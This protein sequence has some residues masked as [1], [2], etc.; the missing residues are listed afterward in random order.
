MLSDY[1][2]IFS[3]AGSVLFSAA[4][5]IARLPMSMIGVGIV[6]MLSQLGD[7]YWLAG[8][9]SAT[10]ALAA[11]AIGPQI[12]RL[13]DRHGQ[14]RVVVPAMA[15][16]VAAIGALL[17]CARYAA[18]AWT[19]YVAAA[20]AG[21]MPS[22]GALVRSRWAE[23]HRESPRLLH[24][25]YSLESVL[26]E[27]IYVVGPILAITLSTSVSAEAGPLATAILLAVGV[28]LFAAQ[29]RTEPPVRHES[30]RPGGSALR[31][32]GLGLLVLTLTSVGV[33]YG[34]VEVATVA[35]AGAHD[36][37]GLSGVLLG[38]Y[39]L[40]SGL[41]GMAFGAISPRGSITRRLLVSVCAMA[42]TMAPL[43]FAPS[44]AALA[45][46]LFVAGVAIAP[47]L[48]TAMGLVNHL[49]PPAQ[50][51]ESITWLVSGLSV[52]VALGYAASGWV[53]DAAGT[54]AGYRVSCAAAV[55][56]AATVFLALPRLTRSVAQRSTA[57]HGP[58]ISG[59]DGAL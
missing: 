30:Q 58:G 24:T 11:A 53:V 29:R 32:P 27:V 56:A 12:S 51:T 34:S 33:T 5:F 16:T 22:M 48:I 42:V 20:A 45:G 52:G 43:L 10:Q 23:L 49:A 14:R 21:C 2:R 15:V 40:G 38:V 50:L 4:G 3:P 8:S 41:A 6:T 28:L 13:V 35:F 55:L 36:H 1:R 46:M 18:P 25:A 26:D 7:E 59:G 17:L 57:E 44:L 19:L 31:V 39:A 9:V 47:T 37:K 54:T